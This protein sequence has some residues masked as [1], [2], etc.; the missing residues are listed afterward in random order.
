MFN[1]DCITTTK[2]RETIILLSCSNKGLNVAHYELASHINDTWLNLIGNRW[3]A[4][5]NRSQ[6]IITMFILV[7]LG[8]IH[9]QY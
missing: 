5:T 8:N 2:Q 6:H 7:N 3:L 1:T 4:V 9:S